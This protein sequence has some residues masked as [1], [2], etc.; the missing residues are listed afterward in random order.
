MLCVGITVL[1]M[2]TPTAAV[3]AEG[4]RS[5]LSMANQAVPA[6]AQQLQSLAIVGLTAS[7]VV[8][9]SFTIG[10]VPKPPPKPEL[11]IARSGTSGLQWPVPPYQFSDGYGPRIA[12]C[13]GCSTFHKGIDLN[14]G[15]GTPIYAM[16]DGVVV[17]TSALD[18]GGLGVHAFIEHQIDGQTVRSTY[19]HMLVGTLRVSVGDWVGSGQL[20]G[21]VGDTGQSV[22]P[23]LH[24]ELYINGG[25]ID[26]VPWFANHGL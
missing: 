1:T 24:F 8:R 15:E 2:S 20:L 11:V 4:N 25:Y 18:D 14:P 23:H 5:L 3:R 26:P 19:A 12:P 6:I 7:P 16:A 22:A 21:N 17:A 10:E 13:E 9:D